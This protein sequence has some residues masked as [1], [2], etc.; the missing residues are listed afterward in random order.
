MYVKNIIIIMIIIQYMLQ[1][2]MQNYGT[3]GADSI[4]VV[5]FSRFSC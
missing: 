5:H 4:R 1:P 2:A 3:R